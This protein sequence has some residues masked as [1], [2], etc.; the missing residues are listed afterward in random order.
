MNF[1][2]HKLNYFLIC[3]FPL[4]YITGPFLPDAIISFIALFYLLYIF[5]FKKWDDFK[6]KLVILI[7]F[8]GSTVF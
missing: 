3:V 2:I 6:S 8:F 7:F 1:H 5:Y 4:I